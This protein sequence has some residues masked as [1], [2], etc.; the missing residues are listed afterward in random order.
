MT[1]WTH[2]S[3]TGHRLLRTLGPGRWDPGVKHPLIHHVSEMALIGF[4]G[5]A[6][7]SGSQLLRVW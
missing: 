1:D 6:E 7:T 5:F 3:V 4:P 2:E